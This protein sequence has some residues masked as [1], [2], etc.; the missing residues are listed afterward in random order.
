MTVLGLAAGC[1]G[2]DAATPSG[3][4]SGSSRPAVVAGGTPDAPV[5]LTPTEDPLDWQPV[6]GSTE[7][8]VTTDG[9]WTLVLDE[10][11][12]EAELSG[13]VDA[14]TPPGVTGPVSDA[15]LGDDYALVVHQDPAEQASATAV[16]TELATGETSVLDGDT[17]GAPTTSGGTWA[18][19]GDRAAY[20]TEGPDGAYC[21]ATADLATGS[22]EVVWCAPERTGSNSAHLSPAGD[23]I[24]TF[25]DAQP[26]CRTLAMVSTTG[27]VPLEG[28]AEIAECQGFEAVS[29][30]EG[31][32]WSVVP[33]PERIEAAQHYARTDAG[34]FDLGPGTSGTLRTC[35]GAAYFVQDP[36][37][38]GDPARLMRW[39]DGVLSTVYTSPAG[40][41]FLAAPRCA[42]DVLTVSSYAEQGDEQV[43][44]RL[45]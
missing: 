22:A 1:S 8:T 42:G 19:D 37:G 25:D 30:D 7:D 14:T 18:L 9:E 38:D 12:G 24:L 17:V 33:D 40:Q 35:G 10:A 13:P 44:A 5:A 23:T 39:A 36:Q 43:S 31:A 21:L 45:G 2:E 20:A 3:P 41:A 34:F 29:L 27:T 28:V 11:A 26:A 16:V 32:V 4:A 15:L 6:P